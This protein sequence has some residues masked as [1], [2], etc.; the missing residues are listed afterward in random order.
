MWRKI[1]AEVQAGTLR[2][3]WR[4][5][6]AR[7]D[8]HSDDD[9]RRIL[10]VPG[11]TSSKKRGAAQA[12]TPPGREGS[13]RVSTSKATSTS[14]GPN[15]LLLCQ[16]LYDPSFP[17]PTRRLTVPNTSTNMLPRSRGGAYVIQ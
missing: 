9:D 2:T 11:W 17:S 13:A 6:P 14:H 5:N 12:P 16:A 10:P 4:R 15:C 3:G 8:T 1:A 7:A